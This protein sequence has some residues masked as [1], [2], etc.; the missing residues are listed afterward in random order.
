L[1]LGSGLRLVEIN[2]ANWEE[3]KERFR[4]APAYKQARDWCLQ[5][6]PQWHCRSED[7]VLLLRL[8]KVGELAAVANSMLIE[9]QWQAMLPY[10]IFSDFAKAGCYT[11]AETDADALRE[12]IAALPRLPNWQAAWFGVAR[13]SFL[14]GSSTEFNL[15]QRAAN[16]WMVRRV[17]D[18]TVAL[19]ATLVPE[20]GFVG[21]RLRERAVALL[22]IGGDEADAMKERLTALYG[23]R[24]TLAHGGA[25]DSKH[26]ND[27]AKHIARF[28]EDVRGLLRAALR[29]VPEDEQHRRDY[30]AGLW[31]ADDEKRAK[32][33]KQMFR[34]ITN[35]AVKS[36]LTE[37]LCSAAAHK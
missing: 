27:L 19:E 22:G 17:L 21:R 37:E 11:L 6:A 14:I 35:P 4:P 3:M 1:D 5:Y 10:P 12:S 26:L 15:R 20:R 36:R 16:P 31:D 24:S 18:F 9:G 2:H 23:V 29:E 7:L 34:S 8:F 33:V 30:L 25:L 13:S 28:E 32:Q